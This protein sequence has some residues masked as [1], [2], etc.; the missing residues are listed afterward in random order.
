MAKISI[1]TPV[2][3][4]EKYLEQCLDSV[5]CQTLQDI[6]IILVDDCSTDSSPAI[7]DRYAKKDS[8]IRVVHNKNSGMGVSYNLGMDKAKGEYIGFAESDDF[9]KNNMFEE[10]YRLAEENGKPDIVKSS[11]FRYYTANNHVD[12]DCSLDSYGD[13]IFSIK[14]IPELLTVRCTVWSAIYRTDFIRSKNV[15]YLETPGASYQDVGFTYKAFCNSDSVVITPEAYLY[16]RQDNENSSINSKEKAN[17]IFDEY[18]EVDRFFNENLE[19]KQWANEAKLIKQF[20]DYY[21][22]YKRIAPYLKHAFI[23]KFASDFKK[24]YDGKELTEGFYSRIDCRFLINIM[25]LV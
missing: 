11:W 25:S 5:V 19:I 18:E 16:Y 2:Y 20:N 22:N 7:C 21:W 23:K 10:L 13:G 14:D 1:I 24:Y 9:I 8:R 3:N 12:K 15:R 17:V 6:E 4:S